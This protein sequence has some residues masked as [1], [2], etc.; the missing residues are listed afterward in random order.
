M[1][2]YIDFICCESSNATVIRFQKAEMNITS[3]K[4]PTSERPVANLTATSSD[5]VS[6]ACL[7][8]FS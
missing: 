2:T 5:A 4:A 3:K 7:R 6:S 1:N 8:A